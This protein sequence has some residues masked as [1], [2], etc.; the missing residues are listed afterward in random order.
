MY[1]QVSHS[2]LNHIL[3]ELKTEIR[4]RDLRHFYTRLGGNFYGIHLLFH[5]LY[6]KRDD[7]KEQM[8]HLVEVMA[9]RYV[10]RH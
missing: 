9:T 7:F 6:G 2:L 5:H 10:Q 8:I 3:D 4:K 1:E